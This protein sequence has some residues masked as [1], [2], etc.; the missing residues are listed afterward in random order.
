MSTCTLLVY[1]EKK[2][3][4]SICACSNGG[5]I[6]TIAQDLHR[7]HIEDVVENAIKAANLT[8][9]DITAIATTVKPGRNIQT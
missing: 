2:L 9:N 8:Y 6:P 1:S 3:K 7:N 5:I 4:K